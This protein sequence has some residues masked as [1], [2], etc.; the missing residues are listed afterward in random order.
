MV[1]MDTTSSP[2]PSNHASDSIATVTMRA[3]LPDHL[4]SAPLPYGGWYPHP[5]MMFSM[6]GMHMAYPHSLY[7][8]QDYF[9]AA[10]VSNRQ[11][12]PSIPG[13]QGGPNNNGGHGNNGMMNNNPHN[14]GNVQHHHHMQVP[15]PPP[16]QDNTPSPSTPY[17]RRMKID[18]PW[19]VVIGDAC[20]SEKQA[21]SGSDLAAI[22]KKYKKM[23]CSYCAE[24]NSSTPWAQ[25]KPRKFEK[26]S[27]VEHEKSAHHA[28]AVA[29]REASY[30]KPDDSVAELKIHGN[31]QMHG[32]PAGRMLEAPSILSTQAA[33]GTELHPQNQFT[34]NL[35]NFTGISMS[36]L[37]Q[38]PLHHHVLQ[39]DQPSP[40]PLHASS[41]SPNLSGNEKDDEPQQFFS[42][43]YNALGLSADSSGSRKRMSLAPDWAQLDGKLR[44]SEKQIQS[45]KDLSKVKKKYK[46]LM[47][48]ICAEF[49]PG[50]AWATMRPRKFETGVFQEHERSINHRKAVE[51]KI[52]QRQERLHDDEAMETSA[53]I[54]EEQFHAPAINA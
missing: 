45:G 15:P 24:F 30:M 6:P 51:Q 10:M 46:M 48:N 44:F 25:L 21:S 20:H 28:K 37:H 22:K 52:A 39:P 19:L 11:M 16:L 26:E 43:V 9:A 17:A 27:F 5:Q 54:K 29:S 49:L 47:C 50:S 8:P 14:G 35:D 41:S 31:A 53:Y 42:D 32:N 23:Y 1:P 7:P 12:I 36:Q 18:Y 2:R 40:P 34:W 13:N 4:M 3:P 38:I 33:L